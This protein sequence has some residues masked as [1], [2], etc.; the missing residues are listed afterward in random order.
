MG[1]LADDGE[2]MGVPFEAG[3]PAEL[4][5]SAPRIPQDAQPSDVPAGLTAGDV[6]LRAAPSA[7]V[8]PRDVGDDVDRRAKHQ[9]ILAV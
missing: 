5:A 4:G 2:S 8:R 3:V 9:R 6:P 7:V 1:D